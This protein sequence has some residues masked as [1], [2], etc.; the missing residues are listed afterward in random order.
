MTIKLKRN[1]KQNQIQAYDFHTIRF[2]LC[3]SFLRRCGVA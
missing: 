2:Q 1:C 3:C